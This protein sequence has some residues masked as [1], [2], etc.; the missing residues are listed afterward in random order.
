MTCCAP[1][2]IRRADGD[3]STRVSVAEDSSCPPLVTST[4]DNRLGSD[5]PLY[6][7]CFVV[8]A[9]K[10]SRWTDVVIVKPPPFFAD[11]VVKEE[12]VWRT[13]PQAEVAMIFDEAHQPPDIASQYFDTALQPSAAGFS[14]DHH[15]L[16][17]EPPAERHLNSCKNAPIACPERP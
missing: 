13:Y 16:P 12:R 4:N 2:Q 7:E 3:I 8:K 9:R 11:M 15:R 1:G 17:D 6:K 14:K 5:C 10:S